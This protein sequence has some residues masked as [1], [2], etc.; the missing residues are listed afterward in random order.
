MHKVLKALAVLAFGAMLAA[1]SEQASFDS[2]VT[3]DTSSEDAMAASMD[4]M[5]AGMSDDD[6]QKLG[7]ALAGIMMMR[8]FEMMGQDLPED[9]VQARMVE[10]LHGLTAAELI[11]KAET[12][13]AELEA[14]Q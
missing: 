3:L 13:A 10:G 9:E 4:A 2:T 6:K 5:T 7:A 8:G 12:L 11:A 14:K 1:C